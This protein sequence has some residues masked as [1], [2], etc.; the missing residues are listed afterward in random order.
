MARPVPD[1][2]VTVVVRVCDD[3]ERIGHALARI[4]RHLRGLGAR[5]ELLVADEGSGDNTVAVAAMM[6]PSVR[7]L[8]ILHAEPGEGCR[9][10][11]ERARGRAVVVYDV[12]SQPPLSALGFALERLRGGADV[13]GVGGRYLVFR[14][15]RAWRAF[16]AL[17]GRSSTAD[18]E[19]R[20]LK[21][22]TSL[23]LACETPHARPSWRTRTGRWFATLVAART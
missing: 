4:A 11:C 13:V 18:L 7:E 14:R 21:R 15:V 1:F 16:D 17:D 3:E 8:E 19:R 2:D 22:A 10:A 23:G 20:F 12:R 6:R 9:R 5:F